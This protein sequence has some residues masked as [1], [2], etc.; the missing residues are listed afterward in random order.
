MFIAHT[1]RFKEIKHIGHISKGIIDDNYSKTILGL[2]YKNN[3][4]DIYTGN[5]YPILDI[6]EKGYIKLNQEAVANKDYVIYKQEYSKRKLNLIIPIVKTKIKIKKLN[7]W[8][9]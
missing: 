6:N 1:C 7:K 5:I 9:E 3:I 4:I 8:G 2:K